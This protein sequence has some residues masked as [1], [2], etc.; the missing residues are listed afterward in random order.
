M[1]ADD[2]DDRPPFAGSWNRVYVLVLGTLVAL[3]AL[4][5]IVSA[6]YR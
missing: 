5:S 1:A 6:V 3:I 2:E 4:F